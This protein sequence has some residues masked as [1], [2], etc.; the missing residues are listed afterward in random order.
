MPVD[1]LK[2]KITL[3]SQHQLHD[4]PETVLLIENYLNNE[5]TAT[6]FRQFGVLIRVHLD[7][8]SYKKG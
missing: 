8:T 4:D 3:T 6:I 5:V 1:I 7:G 2:G